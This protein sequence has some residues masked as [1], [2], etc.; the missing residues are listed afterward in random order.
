VTARPIVPPTFA[1]PSGYATGVLRLELLGPQHNEADH[2]AWMSSI[3]HIRDTPGFSHRWPPID[4]MTLAENRA[5][6]DSHMKRSAAGTDFA[7]TVIEIATGDI[8]GCVYIHPMRGSVQPEHGDRPIEATSWVTA[9]R[10]ELDEPL[11]VAVGSWL[12]TAW[13]F[14]E[15]H[16]RRGRQPTVIHRTAP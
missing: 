9:A 13:P 1:A 11:T 8:V 7:Y 4:G 14:E 5:D 10:A 15:V 3:D 16:Y 6:L 12:A 2:A